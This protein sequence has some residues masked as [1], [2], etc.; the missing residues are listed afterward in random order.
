MIKF[1][2][3]VFLLTLF[4]F[5]VTQDLNPQLIQLIKEIN[6]HPTAKWNAAPTV[7]TNMT[8]EQIAEKIGNI[9]VPM[10][11]ENSTTLNYKKKTELPASFDS[12]VQWPWCISAPRSE[13]QCGASGY[14][15]ATAVVSDRYCTT[16]GINLTL[17]PQDPISC[18]YSDMG[19]KGSYTQK[20]WDYLGYVGAVSERCFPYQGYQLPCPSNCVDG[21]PFLTD[22]H[23][24][25]IS[26]TIPQAYIQQDIFTYGPAL[27]TMNVYQ[28][29]LNY[30]YGVYRYTSGSYVAN[31]AVRILGWS[32][33]QDGIPYW[34]A[35]TAYGPQWGMG[36]VFWIARGYNECNIE[37]N[38]SAALP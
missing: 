3:S 17:A 18:D 25:R 32:V 37:S 14:F 5:A 29:F 30:R 20:V 10:K 11:P 31:I 38:V 1:I 34:I 22:K 21:S 33:S 23:K 28:D 27:A 7:F 9:Y 15:A 2:C 4:A 19:C 16:K 13:G 8:N 12:R 26:Y 36:G 6:C 24:I 35:V